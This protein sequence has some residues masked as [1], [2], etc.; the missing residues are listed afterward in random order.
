MKTPREAERT[1][2][3][4]YD[5]IAETYGV[6]EQP[7][8]FEFPLE[9]LLDKYLRP[10]HI[11]LDVG[12]ANGISAPL[13][14]ARA[15]E[16]HGVD[17]SSKMIAECRRRLE[18][19]K[20]RNAFVYERSATDLLFPDS[21]FDFVYSFATLVLVPQPERAYREIARVLKPGGYALLDITGK[22][23]LSQVYYNRYYRKHGHFGVNA[24]HLP[25]IRR[26][27][28]RLGLQVVETH[29]RGLLDQWRYIPLLNKAAFLDRIAHARRGEPDLDYR[30]SNAL[31]ALAN[32]WLFVLRKR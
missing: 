5:P 22:W 19:E 14:A 9:A 7:F 17:I 32:R 20:I 10:E 30:V 2:N 31:P 25:V 29:A 3:N 16:L 12:I 13:L 6:S 8:A 15:K 21:F 1:S 11:A 23:N 26:I 28:E 4:V 27:F 24:Y 18:R